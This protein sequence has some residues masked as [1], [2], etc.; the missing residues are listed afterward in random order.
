MKYETI[1]LREIGLNYLLATTKL[2][3]FSVS[4]KNVFF[5]TDFQFV[6]YYL[7][8]KNLNI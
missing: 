8:A 5:L 3:F 2:V 1:N 6:N 4:L 7:C